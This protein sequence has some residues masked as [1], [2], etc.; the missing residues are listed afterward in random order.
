MRVRTHL[1]QLQER[2][3]VV[4]FA[5]AERAPLENQVQ[6]A[7]EQVAVFFDD[8]LA[9]THADARTLQRVSQKWRERETERH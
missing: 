3:G 5:E 8:P 6:V 7:H 9:T 4:F 2:G 1:E